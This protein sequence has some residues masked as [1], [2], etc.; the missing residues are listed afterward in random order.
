[1]TDIVTVLTISMFI[2]KYQTMDCGSLFSMAC[3]ITETH[4]SRTYS[5]NDKADEVFDN[6]S[7]R[8]SL[9]SNQLFS[10]WQL[11]VPCLKTITRECHSCTIQCKISV[12]MA[13]ACIVD[14]SHFEIVSLFT[15]QKGVWK[16]TTVSVCPAKIYLEERLYIL[17][18]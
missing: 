12:L 16:L 3:L 8:Q 11:K 7:G 5:L 9:C 14:F 13:A 6:I 1:M 15:A 10:M 18:C 17:M 2:N 4:P